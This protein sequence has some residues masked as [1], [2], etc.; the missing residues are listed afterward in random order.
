MSVFVKTFSMALHDFP[1][2]NSYYNPE[3]PYE[4]E[5]IEN[6]NIT[7]AVDSPY[8]LAVPNIKNC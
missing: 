7:I 1:I 4:F 5:T 6:H 8:G 2:V 3:K